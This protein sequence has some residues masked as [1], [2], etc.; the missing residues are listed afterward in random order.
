MKKIVSV[1]CGLGSN[2]QLFML[3]FK[4]VV[5]SL[6]LKI[7]MFGHPIQFRVKNHKNCILKR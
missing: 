6:M 4:S 3:Q 2:L 5:L 1:L 7:L